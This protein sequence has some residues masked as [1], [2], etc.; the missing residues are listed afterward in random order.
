MWMQLIGSVKRTLS[1]KED[2]RA[3]YICFESAITDG[4]SVGKRQVPDSIPDY[5]HA[6]PSCL[7]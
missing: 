7:W 4:C 2:I 1:V 6:S 5:N 3:E